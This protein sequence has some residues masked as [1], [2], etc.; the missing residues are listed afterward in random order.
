MKTPDLA[1]YFCQVPFEFANLDRNNTTTVCCWVYRNIGV[2]S[3]ETTVLDVWNSPEAQE[4][5]SSI[6]DG[7]YRHCNKAICPDIQA[8]K[9][10]LRTEVTD[11][12]YRRVIDENIVSLPSGPK[13]YQF[14][15]D[16][17]CNLS[18][19]SCRTKLI[20]TTYGP[21]YEKMERTFLAS[22]N[23]QSLLE[24]REISITGSGDPFASKIYRE[25]LINLDGSRYPE[26]QINLYTNGVLFDD[27]MWEKLHK[28]HRNIGHV[29]ISLDAVNKEVYDYVRRNGNLERVKRNI[30][31][32]GNLRA[33]GYFK[34]LAL[35]FVVQARNF[36]EMHDFARYAGSFPKTTAY[37]QR[38]YNWDTYSPAE[39]RLHDIFDPS[40]SEH[41]EFLEVLRD[42]IFEEPHVCLSNLTPYREMALK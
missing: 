27:K 32:L 1:N 3:E 30:D 9:L 22:I 39:F 31:F 37:F 25:F 26:L 20:F 40:H 17:S 18:C 24:A 19:P 10:P 28:I 6:L 29:R 21:E 4:I 15:N 5:R 42:P 12:F 13:I 41:A 7:S 8:R 33:Q 2:L 36:R 11:P 38:L 16:P 35:C 34:D 14:N 23:H